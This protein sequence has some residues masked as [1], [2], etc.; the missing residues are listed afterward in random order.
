MLIPTTERCVF[1]DEL[2]VLPRV[3]ASSHGF[4]MGSTLLAQ[5]V[6]RLARMRGAAE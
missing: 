6:G 5:L 1:P 2:V 4:A 3:G